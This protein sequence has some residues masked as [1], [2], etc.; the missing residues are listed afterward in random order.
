MTMHRILLAL[1]LI[2]TSA[3]PAAADDSGSTAA[4]H[5]EAN[6]LY[7]E[8]VRLYSAGEYAGALDLFESAYARY[9]DPR[10]LFSMATTLRQIGRTVDA[11]NAYQRFIDDPRAESQ[12]VADTEA[13]LKLLDA[14][15]GTIVIGF[16]GPTGEVQ[17]EDGRW[18]TAPHR[19]RVDAGSFVVRGRRDGFTAES[20]G[21]V[22]AGAAV[23]ITLHWQP[24][25]R[26][27]PVVTRR[28]PEPTTPVTTPATSDDDAAPARAGTHWSRRKI[29]AATLGGGG[30]VLAASALVLEL[31]ARSRVADAKASC[32][33]LRCGE[34]AYGHARALLDGAS[35]RRTAAIVLSGAAVAA[36][37]GGAVLW[38]TARPSHLLITPTAADDEGAMLVVTGRF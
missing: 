38:L 1:A 6:A 26:P 11:A 25:E 3:G 28:D 37:A 33:D 18:L 27:E 9:P 5:R 23:E 21:R 15:V 29:V 4:E 35:T 22:A 10:I 14:T 2:A 7:K 32:P 12:L 19:I 31:G 17:V 8:G 20:A 24:I 30:L 36:I 13:V 34:P 16:D